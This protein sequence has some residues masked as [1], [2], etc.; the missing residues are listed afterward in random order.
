MSSPNLIITGDGSH[1]LLNTQMNETYHSVHGAIQESRYVFIQQGLAFWCASHT[2]TVSIL[3]VGFGTGLNALLSLEFSRIQNRPVRYETLEAYPLGP[4]IY[5][6]LNYGEKI[7]GQDWLNGLHDLAWSATHRVTDKFTFVKHQD[8]LQ[9]FG[10]VPNA[11]DVI[12]FDAFAPSR[13]PEMWDLPLLAK[14]IQ[15]LRPSGVFVTYCAKGQLKRDLRQQG[16][17]VE[18]LPG[19]PGKKEMVRGIVDHATK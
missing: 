6:C 16:L 11:Y 3:E 5:R 18:T 12:Y 4:E 2:E 10:I 19:P 13:Q 9:D 15:G 7:M 17:K 8:K 14:V 1:S